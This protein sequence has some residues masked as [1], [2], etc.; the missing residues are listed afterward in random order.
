MTPESFHVEGSTWSL[1]IKIIK[2][3]VGIGRLIPDDSIQQER[4]EIIGRLI[5]TAARNGRV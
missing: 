3:I 4:G 2:I 1:K 5:N